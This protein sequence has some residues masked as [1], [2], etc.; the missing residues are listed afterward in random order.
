MQSWEKVSEAVNKGSPDGARSGVDM[1]CHTRGITEKDILIHR[2]L[3]QLARAFYS[4]TVVLSI[5]RRG[6]EASVD[7]APMEDIV[8]IENVTSRRRF[9]VPDDDSSF[10]LRAQVRGELPLAHYLL[11]LISSTVCCIMCSQ[12]VSFSSF[13][14]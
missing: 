6:K 7:T 8:G 11:L 1:I 3:H 10:L 13:C 4:G 14:E 5:K 2:E 9:E 12:I